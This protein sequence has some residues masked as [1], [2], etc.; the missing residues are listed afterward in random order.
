MIKVGDKFGRLTVLEKSE[1]YRNP[2]GYIKES[3]WLCQC[4]CGNTK[5]ILRSALMTGR[6][7]SCGCLF[8][9]TVKICRLING[10]KRNRKGA[11]SS[12]TQMKS[13]CSD[14]NASGYEYYGGRGIKVCN[15]WKSF[16]LF[17]EDMGDRPEGFSIDRIDVNGDYKPENCK[18][19]SISEQSYNRRNNRHIELNGEIKPL[20]KWIE[21][22][23]ISRSC[24][25]GRLRRGW[26]PAEAF[27]GRKNKINH[28]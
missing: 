2:E 12:W 26:T 11:Y 5:V 17:Y 23:G 22:F 4:E 21:Q 1:P 24:I 20:G 7:R 14:K 27:N 28:K 15:R 19:S 18:W 16:D 13:R 6:T 25:T 10:V 8:T 3:R 9:E